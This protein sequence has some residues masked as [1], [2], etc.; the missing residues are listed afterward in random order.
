[1]PRGGTAPTRDDN[2]WQGIGPS[3]NVYDSIKIYGASAANHNINAYSE[4]R[5]NELDLMHPKPRKKAPLN[6]GEG[7]SS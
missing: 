5:L 1:M 2:S 7:Y 3:Y 6:L 4:H